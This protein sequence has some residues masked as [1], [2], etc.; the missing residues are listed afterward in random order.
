MTLPLP[1]SSSVPA[2][3]C[4]SVPLAAVLGLR[5]GD[6]VTLTAGL[7]ADAVPTALA[8]GDGLRLLAPASRSALTAVLPSNCVCGPRRPC[9]SSLTAIMLPV[10][11]VTA[12][13]SQAPRPTR[14]L[15]LTG[16]IVAA[17][18]LSAGKAGNKLSHRGREI[19]QTVE[20]I[21]QI[22]VILT[23]GRLPSAMWR[24]CCWWKTTRLSAMHSSVR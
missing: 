24:S 8:A 17:G 23:P 22:G 7:L 3:P 1:D 5:L 10:V 21:Q 15:E 16:R 11:A 19:P 4:A 14:N 6:C 12:P 13:S 18:T 2:V 9:A 20:L